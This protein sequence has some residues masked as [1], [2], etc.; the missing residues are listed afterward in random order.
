MNSEKEGLEGI[1]LHKRGFNILKSTFK[2]VFKKIE[3]FYGSAAE[4]KKP[5]EELFFLFPDALNCILTHSKS[6][7]IWLFTGDR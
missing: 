7:V 3:V 5:V 4:E 2:T 6:K 1:R